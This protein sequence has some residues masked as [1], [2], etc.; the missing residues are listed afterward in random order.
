MLGGAKPEDLRDEIGE[1]DRRHR[2]AARRWRG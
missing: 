1:L 2:Y